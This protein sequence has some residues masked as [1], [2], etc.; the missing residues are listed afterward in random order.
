[1]QQ[2]RLARIGSLLIVLGAL[3]GC[4]VC[5]SAAEEML[6]FSFNSGNGGG[7]GPNGL[8]PDAKGNLYGTTSDGVA[9]EVSPPE[10]AGDPWTETVLYRF[11][12]GADGGHPS[13]SLI[14]DNAG[15]LY[16]TAQ[17]GGQSAT[18]ECSLAGCGVV[19]QLSPPAQPG[20]AWTETTLYAFLG[21]PDGNTPWAGLIFDKSGNLY[22]T[23][24]SGGGSNNRDIGC[25][26]AFLLSPPKATGGNWTET[27]LNRFTC[28]ANGGNPYAGL[29]FAPGGAGPAERLYGTL[30]SGGVQGH[31][32]VFELT[33]PAE[34]GLW[35]ET[36]IHHFMD[37]D[38]NDGANPQDAP[39]FDSAGNLYGTTL[40]G[41][42]AE[43]GT[44]FRLTPPVAPGSPWAETILYSFTGAGD[45]GQPYAG[46]LVE[47]G[48]LF[49]MA[50][51]GGGGV[52]GADCGTTG[53]GTVF[54]LSPPGTAGGPWIE[55]TLHEFSGPDG[56]KPLSSLISGKDGTLLGATAGG[57]LFD[58]GTIFRIVP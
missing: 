50:Y 41:G 52:G 13:S 29:A 44:V 12:G 15:N 42:S 51:A 14:F 9:F 28:G 37:G 45:G 2:Q 18:Y 48:N 23:T 57:G 36:A 33:P 34:G 8:T 6:L 54:E 7:I 25:G 26:T 55:T 58:D 24:F 56:A 17:V 49:G 21:S 4:A 32:V 27:V 10:V 38:P 1:M 5:A 43:A 31:G 22:G 47:N 35:I 30:S 20:G 53:C 39:T 40:L 16:G 3:S 11:T 19:F 46:L